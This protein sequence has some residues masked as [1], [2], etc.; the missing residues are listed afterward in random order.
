VT[1]TGDSGTEVLTV[2][3]ETGEAFGE[4][5]DP[6]DVEALK[7]ICNLDPRGSFNRQKSK[8]G[9]KR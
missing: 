5:G 7:K 1:V 3:R 9:S 2:T 6:V 4:E 8:G